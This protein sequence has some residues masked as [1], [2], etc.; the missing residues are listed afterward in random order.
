MHAESETR[1][2][3][4]R[5]DLAHGT[6]TNLERTIENPVTGER[7]TSLATAEETNGELLKVKAEIPAGTPGV[8]LHY[9]LTF[10]EGFEVLEGRLDLRVGEGHLVLGSD[11]SAMVPLGTAHR[12]WNAGSK[13]AIFE[14]EIRPARKMEQSLRAMVG[15]ARDGKTDDRG[16]PK[17]IFELAP[18]LR[19]LRELHSGDAALPAERRVRNTGEVGPREGLRPR[20]LAVHQV[21]GD[22][23]YAFQARAGLPGKLLGPPVLPAYPGGWIGTP[24]T[25][26]RFAN[27]SFQARPRGERAMVSH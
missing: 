24:A 26:S 10:T 14:A 19:T 3:N 1:R 18:T 8:P 12:F 22:V 21:T 13:P 20:V 23:G 15:L 4:M 11:E 17:N 16:V 9:H 7:Y 25:Q 27:W 5:A 6:T 2:T